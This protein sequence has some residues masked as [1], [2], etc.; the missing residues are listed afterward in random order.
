M[1]RNNLKWEPS[2]NLFCLGTV[3][4]HLDYSEFP[5]ADLDLYR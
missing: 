3:F 2:M 4:S 5:E 1:K